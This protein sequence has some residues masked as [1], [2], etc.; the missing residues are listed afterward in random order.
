MEGHVG[1]TVLEFI[2][3]L[4]EPLRS[5]LRLPHPF[6][7]VME[8]DQPL[9][10]RLHMSGCC[11]DTMWVDIEYPRPHVMLLRRGWKTFASA[12]KLV[13]G[14]VLCFKQVEADPLSIEV[15]GHS[16]ARLGCCAE[17]S[18]DGESSSLSNSDDK[19]TD[20]EDSGEEPPVVKH[21]DDDSDSC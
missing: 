19:D 5:R 10:L 8:V 2:V 11:N 6:A 16:G 12:H 7:R 13:E 18:S 15:F 3:R 9:G 4:R 17:S 20:G 21:E 14:H 1:V